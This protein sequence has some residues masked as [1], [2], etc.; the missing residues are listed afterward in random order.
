[1]YRSR[2]IPLWRFLVSIALLT[3]GPL[4][5]GQNETEECANGYG[6]S[7]DPG[8]LRE[9]L[10]AH[11]QWLNDPDTG[12]RAELCRMNLVGIELEEAD[13]RRVK[14]EEAD[15]RRAKL[16]G[17]N[18]EKA[19][20]HRANLAGADLTGANLAESVMRKTNLEG[21]DFSLAN[22]AGANLHKSIA[23][24][25]RFDGA[26][27]SGANLSK[28]DLERAIF[29]GANLQGASLRKARL[30]LADMR[31]AN[32]DRAK[33]RQT[34]FTSANLVGAS[35]LDADFE[36]AVLEG[37]NVYPDQ[38]SQA[39]GLTEEQVERTV[40][41]PG[42]LFATQNAKQTSEPEVEV[43]GAT[44]ESPEVS[45]V[46]EATDPAPEPQPEADTAPEPEPAV[47]AVAEP[48]S[49]TSME[50]P[51]ITEGNFL[52]QLGSYRLES[53][54]HNVWNEVTTRHPVLFDQFTARVVEVDLD[55]GKWH[56][57]QA[58]PFQ[59]RQAAIALCTDYQAAR[60]DAPCVPV[61]LLGN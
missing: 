59:S 11:K 14:L 53:N 4:S 43:V 5:W 27:L 51:A 52:V 50:Q 13:L 24:G 18:L 21:S 20:M 35:M 25:A 47:V 22:L 19:H 26:D 60:P 45:T 37:T 40:Q 56:R 54:A 33:V 42:N 1:M 41:M 2:S 29:I 48:G 7:P 46:E 44:V 36:D 34:D 39:Q 16:R 61:T 32:L 9:M 31:E 30:V 23:T 6:L 57:L 10:N 38:L 8:T 12:A 58:G 17:A 49:E 28:T 3:V 55:S 15:L